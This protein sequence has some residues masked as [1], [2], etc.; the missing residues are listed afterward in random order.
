MIYLCRDCGRFIYP[1]D[2]DNEDECP[3]CGSVRIFITD[4][5]EF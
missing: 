4:E 5:D 1:H 3:F 2:R